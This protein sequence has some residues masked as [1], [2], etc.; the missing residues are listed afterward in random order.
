MYTNSEQNTMFLTSI[1]E[2]LTSYRWIL[3]KIPPVAFK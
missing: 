2:F 1:S 3:D